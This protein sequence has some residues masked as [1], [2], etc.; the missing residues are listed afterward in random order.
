MSGGDHT[1]N[2]SLIQ[3]STSSLRNKNFQIFLGYFEILRFCWMTVVLV[4][5]FIFELFS[6]NGARLSRQNFQVRE[7]IQ[8]ILSMESLICGF[9]LRSL[10]KHLNYIDFFKSIDDLKSI[11]RQSLS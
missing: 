8:V 9:V 5:P 3:F 2:S 4:E 1:K 10:E 11:Q 6:R 7:Q